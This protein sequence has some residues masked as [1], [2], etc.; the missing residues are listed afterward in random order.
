VKDFRDRVAVITGASSGIGQALAIEL[1]DRGCHLAICGAKNIK[2][3]AETAAEVRARGRRVCSRRVDVA[4]Q[5]EVDD[6]ACQVVETLGRVDIL[7]NNAGVGLVAPVADTAMDDFEWLLQINLWG[8]IYATKAFLPQLCLRDAQVVNVSSVWGLWASPGQA[9]YTTS[10]FA[11]RGF[12][13][14]LGQELAG[15]GVGVTLVLPGGVKTDIARNSR[16]RSPFGPLSDRGAAIDMLDRVALT[17]SKRAARIIVRAMMRRQRRV[18]V[19]PDAHLLDL[20]QR[21][22]P[23][24][25]QALIPWIFRRLG[26]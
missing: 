14:T 7:I 21:L 13:E 6:F 4:E 5:S 22:F 20:I 10:K 18:L 11:L 3:L 16:F 8:A 26:R 9:A 19:G 2:G 23:S 15:S 25:H 12:S 24:G 1:A 17:S